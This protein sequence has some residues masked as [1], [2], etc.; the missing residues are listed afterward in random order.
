M[1]DTTFYQSLCECFTKNQNC[2]QCPLFAQGHSGDCMMLIAE[3]IVNRKNKALFE[4]ET[5][6]EANE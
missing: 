5:E 4:E 3:E 1:K 2:K 6:D